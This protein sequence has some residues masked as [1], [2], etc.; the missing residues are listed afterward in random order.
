MKAYTVV[1]G[2]LAEDFINTKKDTVVELL[3]LGEA[4]RQVPARRLDLDLGVPSDDRAAL[5]A[6]PFPLDP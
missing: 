2:P 6:L 5:H 3:D 1:I 4:V